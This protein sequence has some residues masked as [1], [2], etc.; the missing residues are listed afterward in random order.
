MIIQVGSCIT[1]VVAE[2]ANEGFLCTVDCYVVLE[3]LCL[4]G[5]VLTMSTMELENSCMGVLAVQHL[6]E[7]HVSVSTLVTP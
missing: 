3:C 6:V 4:V 2:G 7:P 5:L 1:G